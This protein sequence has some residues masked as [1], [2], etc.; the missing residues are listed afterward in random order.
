MPLRTF[1][2]TGTPPVP[3]H[4]RAHPARHLAGDVR[5]AAVDLHRARALVGA[6]AGE[7]PRPRV[8]FEE[9]ARGDHLRDVEA[10]AE[11]PA[12]AAERVGGH[13]RHG[14]Q[15]DGRPDREGAEDE[16]AE[17]TRTGGGYAPVER[18]R[19][20]CGGGHRAPV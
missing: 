6:A 10:R 13:A 9:A 12:E 5:V 19:E 8:A 3:A 2:V 15:D 18:A 16:R 4:G 11:R 7:E 1:T 14:G 17:L 20:A